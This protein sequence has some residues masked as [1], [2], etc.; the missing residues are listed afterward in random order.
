MQP[1]SNT[2]SRLIVIKENTV[3]C[4]VFKFFF[5]TG[6]VVPS[7]QPDGRSNVLQVPPATASELGKCHILVTQHHVASTAVA[8]DGRFNTAMM[9]FLTV[10][11]LPSPSPVL[12][13][14]ANVLGDDLYM[15]WCFD[16]LVM[17]G[18]GFCFAHYFRRFRLRFKFPRTTHN[19]TDTS[20][21][22]A[23]YRG[24]C[25]YSHTT[26]S[27]MDDLS[28]ERRRNIRRF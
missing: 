20:R 13:L 23:V 15:V 1:R 18:S 5:L 27:L 4:L 6:M 12:R 16:H 19:S 2:I 22:K 10:H 21:I 11:I 26:G 24:S 3:A 28:N 7:T 17:N 9:P 14:M 8:W 25:I